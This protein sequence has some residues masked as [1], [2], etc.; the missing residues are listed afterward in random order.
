M[1]AL[2]DTDVVLDVVLARA[3]FAKIAAELLDLNEQGLFEAYISG[4][5]PINIFYIAR[6]ARTS[7]D[8]KQAIRELLLSVRVCPIDH[9]ILAT[10]LATP[11]SDYEDAVQ[12]ASAVASQLDAIVTR[13]LDDYKNATLPVFSPTDFLNKLKSESPE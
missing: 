6:K 5:T 1:R 13:N 7:G 9:S 12:H 3:P 8:L 11:F 10:A 2:L 4:I